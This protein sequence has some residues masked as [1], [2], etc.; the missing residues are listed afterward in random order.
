MEKIT[1]YDIAAWKSHLVE[2]REQF[3]QHIMNHSGKPLTTCHDYIKF[4]TSIRSDQETI[5]D[6]EREQKSSN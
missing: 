6:I 4:S 5:R 1:L 2:M 3:A